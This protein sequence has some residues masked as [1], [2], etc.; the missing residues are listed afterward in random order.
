MSK[1]NDRYGR[2][3]YETQNPRKDVSSDT[4]N[5]KKPK[6]ISVKSPLPKKGWEKDK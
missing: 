6:T 3:S 2:P 4:K 5:K 1:N